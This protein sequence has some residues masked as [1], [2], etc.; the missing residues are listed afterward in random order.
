MPELPEVETV[1]RGLEPAMVGARIERVEQR[2]PDLRFPFPER[3][4]A[5]LTGQA[6]RRARPAGEIPARPTS[7]RGEVLVM[8]LGMTGRF[9]VDA[10]R[11]HARPRRVPRRGRRRERPRPCRLPPLERR[12]ASPTTTRAASASWTSCR[13]PSSTPRRI[14]AISGSSRSATS[15]TARLIARLFARQAGAAQG[16]AARPAPDRRARQH[17]C[18]R[19]AVPGAAVAATAPAGSLATAGGKPRAARR[20]PRRGD[21]RGARARRSRPAARR[22]ATTPRPTA[23]SAISSTASGS[24]TARASPARREGCGGDRAA[25]RPV[26]PLDLLLPASASGADR[27]LPGRLR[28]ASDAGAFRRGV[29]GLRNHPRRDPRQGRADHAQPAAGAERAERDRSSAS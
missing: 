13:G 5:R 17:L 1:R 15:S 20:S 25:H 27:L 3:F 16:G 4:A 10:G 28:L 26:G 7:R 8:H 21:P 19:G 11:A 14:S 6:G 29:H 23:R 18:L 22:C 2:R 9:R 12:R 24:M